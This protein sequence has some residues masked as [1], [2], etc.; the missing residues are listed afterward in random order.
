MTSQEK[1]DNEIEAL[2]GLADDDKGISIADYVKGLHN[3][4]PKEVQMKFDT[5]VN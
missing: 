3:V 1:I 5:L 2:D 4:L